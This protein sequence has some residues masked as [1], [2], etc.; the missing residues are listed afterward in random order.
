M[1]IAIDF[2]GTCVTHAFPKVGKDIG[3]ARILRAL[4]EKKHQ[5]IL[6]TM[7]DRDTLKDAINW[8]AENNIPL[9]AVNNNPSQHKWTKSPKVFAHLYIDDAALGTPLKFDENISDRP[10]VNWEKVEQ[11]LK[12]KEII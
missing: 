4:T 3:A 11:L 1:I 9:Y 5:L 8:F 10:F 2:D 7:R 6:Y 12:E